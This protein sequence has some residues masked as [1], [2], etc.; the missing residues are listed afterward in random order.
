VL[1]HLF[2]PSLSV[3]FFAIPE[4]A[5]ESHSYSPSLGYFFVGKCRE[6]GERDTGAE[7]EGG[8]EIRG[9]DCEPRREN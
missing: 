1:H 3:C 8:K 5:D 9:R 6:G 7:R 4:D 2:F